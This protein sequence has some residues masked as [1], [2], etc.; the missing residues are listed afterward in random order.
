MCILPSEPCVCRKRIIDGFMQSSLRLVFG[1]EE[2]SNSEER[3]GDIVDK[4]MTKAYS[5]LPLS[6][7]SIVARLSAL[8]TMQ[9]KHKSCRHQHG[10][11]ALS[12]KVRIH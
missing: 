7:K 10:C 12:L 4:L 8:K 11:L 6:V 1:S 2:E 9:I 5:M 3:S